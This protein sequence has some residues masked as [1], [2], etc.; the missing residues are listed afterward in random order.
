[1]RKVS[2]AGRVASAWYDDDT[3]TINLGITDGKRHQV[4]LYLLDW[5]YGGR[6]QKVELLNADTGAV[7]DSRIVTNFGGGQYLAWNVSGRVKFRLTR[8]TGINVVCS[9]LFFD[10]EARPAGQVSLPVISSVVA[11]RVTSGGVA[12]TWI[13]DKTADSGIQYGPTLPYA[14]TTTASTQLASTIR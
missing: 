8:L 3:L 1:M 4:A 13:T 11:S 6:T 7:L 10:L 12:I 5:D 14:N 9:G 2:A